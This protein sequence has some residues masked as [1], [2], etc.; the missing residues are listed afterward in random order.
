[1]YQQ[2]H[3]LLKTSFLESFSYPPLEMMATGGFA[4]VVPNDGNR[5]YLS[6]G[7][8]CL[9]YPKGEIKQGLQAIYTICEDEELREKLY[10]NGIETARERDWENIAE[11]I[12]FFYDCKSVERREK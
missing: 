9:L 10:Y 7:E 12:L 2:C 3:I 11:N 1:M 8:N 5:E 6:D 4:V